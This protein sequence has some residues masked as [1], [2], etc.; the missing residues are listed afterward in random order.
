MAS[1]FG[2]PNSKVLTT[3]IGDVI[4]YFFDLVLLYLDLHSF[5]NQA[6]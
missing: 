3:S 6:V 4:W 1:G 2:I 5:W